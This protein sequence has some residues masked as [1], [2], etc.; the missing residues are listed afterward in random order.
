MKKYIKMLII[1]IVV[2]FFYMAPSLSISI[3]KAPYAGMCW[4]CVE[5]EFGKT[6]QGAYRGEMACMQEEQWH[7][8]AYGGFCLVPE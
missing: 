6:C 4:E 3:A 2:L 7:C 1:F 8:H 5:Y